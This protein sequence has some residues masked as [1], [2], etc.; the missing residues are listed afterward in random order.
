MLL[1]WVRLFSE[2]YQN[3]ALGYSVTQQKAILQA[4][5]YTLYQLRQKEKLK[6]L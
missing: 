6:A 2:S 4:Y 3:K 1:F 5:A